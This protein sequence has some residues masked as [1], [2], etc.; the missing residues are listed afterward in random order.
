MATSMAANGAAPASAPKS[1]DDTTT[2]VLVVLGLGALAGAGYL[3]FRH[4]GS[5]PPPPPGPSPTVYHITLRQRFQTK[6]PPS[7]GYDQ[8]P[9]ALPLYQLPVGGTCARPSQTTAYPP[10]L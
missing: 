5:T 6:C 2:G 7:Y 3:V 1:S 10:S 4:H 8:V 9:T